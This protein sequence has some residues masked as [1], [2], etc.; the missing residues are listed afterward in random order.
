MQVTRMSLPF[1]FNERV[2]EFCNGLCWHPEKPLTEL[3]LSYGFKDCEAR[4]ATVDAT[5][6]DFMLERGHVYD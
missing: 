1:C 4:V 5:E 6:V 2:I 3:V